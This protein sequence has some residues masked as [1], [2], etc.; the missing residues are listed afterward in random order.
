MSTDTEKKALP[1]DADRDNGQIQNVSSGDLDEK[2]MEMVQNEETPPERRSRMRSIVLAN[3]SACI[4][5]IGFTVISP[6]MYPYMKQ[7]SRF[8]SSTLYLNATS[9]I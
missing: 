8:Y 4:M 3:A 9:P 2:S 7:V 6:G 5:L 1:E